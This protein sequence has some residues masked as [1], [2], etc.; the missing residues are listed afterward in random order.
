MFDFWPTCGYRFL[1]ARDN[2]LVVTDDFLRML[3][4]R[5]EVAP[6]AESCAAELKLHEALSKEPRRAVASAELLSMKDPDAQANYRVMLKFRD[7]LLAAPTLEAAYMN[8]F[9]GDGVDVPPLFVFQLTQ[10]FLRHIL[11]NDAD[12]LEARMT[13]CLFRVQ[14]ISVLEDGAV[15]AADDETIETF[16]ETGGFGSLGELLKKQNT[17]TRSIDLDV[18]NTENKDEYWSRDERFDFAVSLNR[19]QPALD[20]LMHVLEK[21]VKHFLGVEVEIKHR[22]EIDDKTW[23]WHVG[24][25]ATASSI[26]N[27]LYN[28]EAV[29][30]ERMA[31]L[32][33]LFELRFKNPSD[34]RA[35]IAG[36]P[37][38]LAMAMDAENKLKLKPQNLL[39]NLPLNRA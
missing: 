7:R 36:K 4:L 31:R 23:V 3:Y 21:W 27:D 9:K 35:N 24:L 28:N 14:K 2:A 37:V 1:E 39:L 5:P 38:Y 6:I 11:G 30:E 34:M 25:D 22:R 16:S 8:L 18:L 17:P 26:L 13:E 12:P 19:G 15:M 29:E 32:L 33:C 20:A 10:I